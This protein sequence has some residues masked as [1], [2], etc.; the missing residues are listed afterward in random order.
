MLKPISQWFKRT[1]NQEGAMTLTKDTPDVPEL[2]DRVRDPIT[3]FTGIV[4]VTAHYLNGCSRC[5]VAPEEMKDGLPQ[6]EQHFDQAQLTVV[7]KGAFKPATVRVIATAS[8]RDVGPGGPAREN[9]VMPALPAPA[10]IP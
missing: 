8:R 10:R 1:I 7:D 6:M 2:G 3:G 4:T 9:S 5:G